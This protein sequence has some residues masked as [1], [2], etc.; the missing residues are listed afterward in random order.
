VVKTFSVLRSNT[1]ALFNSF[2][3]NVL[4]NIG[5]ADGK[6]LSAGIIP[7]IICGHEMHHIKVIED[8]Y[9]GKY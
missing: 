1:I 2:E 9:I 7:Y 6:E 5:T 4:N 8:K 3:P